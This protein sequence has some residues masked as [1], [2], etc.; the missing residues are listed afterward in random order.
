[1]ATP[2]PRSGSRPLSTSPNPPRAISPSMRGRRQG[3]R[4]R[5]SS[6]GRGRQRPSSALPVG[7]GGSTRLVSRFFRRTCRA[8]KSCPRRSACGGRDP[9]AE[10][11]VAGRRIGVGQRGS[12]LLAEDCPIPLSESLEDRLERALGRADPQGLGPGPIAGGSGVEFQHVGQH[13]LGTEAAGG[14]PQQ[15]VDSHCSRSRRRSP[16]PSSNRTSC[17][18]WSPSRDHHGAGPAT[19]GTSRRAAG[20]SSGS[21]GV[22][23]CRQRGCDVIG[24]R[25]GRLQARCRGS[26]APISS[27]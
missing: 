3:A 14:Q 27:D 5:S 15:R 10:F 21:D 7:D 25:T 9:L 16:T 20:A 22:A 8:G 12:D 19:A 26:A 13:T 17:E 23:T 11:V 2:R 6:N 24:I 1:M 4:H 18:A